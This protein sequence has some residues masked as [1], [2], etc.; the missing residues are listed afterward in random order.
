VT[1]EFMIMQLVFEFTKSFSPFNVMYI[2]YL[3]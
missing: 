1:P 3:K 2:V